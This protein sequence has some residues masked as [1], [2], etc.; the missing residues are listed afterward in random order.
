[1][2]HIYLAGTLGNLKKKVYHNAGDFNAVEVRETLN[3]FDIELKPGMLDIPYGDMAPRS[4]MEWYKLRPTES[5]D[6]FES[7]IINNMA[8]GDLRL[9]EQA[10][11]S[12]RGYLLEH[13]ADFITVANRNGPDDPNPRYLYTGMG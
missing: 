6:Y 12:L 5:R 8:Q 13:T 4:L 9:T 2:D 10:A 1:V 11:T 3:K 7:L